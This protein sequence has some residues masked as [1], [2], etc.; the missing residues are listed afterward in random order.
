[1]EPAKGH[2]AIMIMAPIH[3]TSI[4]WSIWFKGNAAVL[5]KAATKAKTSSQVLKCT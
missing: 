5:T 1:M 4:H 2:K 3:S